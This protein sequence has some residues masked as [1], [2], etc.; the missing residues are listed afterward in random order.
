MADNSFTKMIGI[1]LMVIGI[2]LA[3]WGYDMSG[4]LDSQLNQTF[5]GSSSDAVM[6]RY[7]GGAASFIAGLF[8]FLKK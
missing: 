5:T 7:I 4:G 1:P 2:G 8:L 3:Y 6:F